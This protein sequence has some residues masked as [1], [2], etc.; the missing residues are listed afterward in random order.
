MPWWRVHA[1][2]LG[3]SPHM[4]LATMSVRQRYARILKAET[5]A[6]HERKADRIVLPVQAL[7]GQ[8]QEEGDAGRS[9][10][11][12]ALESLCLAAP[13]VPTATREH[14]LGWTLQ[15][16]ATAQSMGLHVAAVELAAGLLDMH[17]LR[18]VGHDA[19]AHQTPGPDEH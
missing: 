12:H 14:L 6:V 17:A 3:S 9:I 19:H 10:V 11:A 2:A 7:V 16:A 13:L 18:L 4:L 5:H 8:G 15:L 1:R